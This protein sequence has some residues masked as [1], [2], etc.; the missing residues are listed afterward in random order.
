MKI[1]GRDKER[2]QFQ[3]FINSDSSEF[4][5]VYGR[6]RV[7]KTFLIREYFDNKF[8]FYH[9]GVA[10]SNKETQLSEFNF[11]LN[12]TAKLPNTPVNSW[13]DAFHKLEFLLEYSKN[14]GKK[15]VFL[16]EL[17]WMDTQKSGFLQALELFWNKWASARN[18]ILLIVCGSATSWIFDKLI[19]NRGG[20]HNRITRQIYLKPFTLA[21][22]EYFFKEKKVTLNRKQIA[23]AYMIFGGIPYYLNF[24]KKNLSLPQNVDSILFAEDAPLKNEF[25]SLYQS[26][27]NHSEKYILIVKAIGRKTK[28]L[29]RD[30]I[31]SITKLTNGGGFSKLLHDLELSGFIRKYYSLDKKEKDA[32]FQLV[33]FYTLFY[34][35]F[36]ENQRHNDESY[37]SHLVDNARHRTWSGFSFEQICLYHLPLIKQ[38]LGISGILTNAASWIGSYNG[39]RVQIDL[40]IDRNDGVINLCE[41]KF[42]KGVYTIDKNT[43]QNLLNKMEV[44]RQNTKSKKAIHL[45]MITP[46][47]VF[48]NEYSSEINSEIVLDDLFV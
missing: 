34:F 20:L 43:W 14:K 30:E 47:G 31:L 46:F 6:R 39:N 23:E 35:N 7:G 1:I 24:F 16:D 27:F 4:V 9:T 2:K 12:Q 17:P 38:R 18:D 48:Q 21:E 28:G 13:F 29:T 33:D 45:T 3:E 26:L 8:D 15:I 19:N 11:A 25:L 40:L 22:C 37:W 44:F 36:I 41:L 10:N 5:V 32:I 42:A